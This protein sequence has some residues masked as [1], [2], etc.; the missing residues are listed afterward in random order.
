MDRRLLGEVHRVLEEGAG[1]LRVWALEVGIRGLR[2]GLL[3]KWVC[4]L[5]VVD[6]VG[7]EDEIEI[8][9]EGDMLVVE[10][11]GDEMAWILV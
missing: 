3:D 1:G 4:K 11:I 2:K 9:M 7:E 6:G 5:V 10:I 8:E